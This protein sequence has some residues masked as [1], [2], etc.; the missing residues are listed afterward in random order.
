MFSFLGNLA[1]KKSFKL[2]A[3]IS[4]T[5]AFEIEIMCAN[6]FIIASRFVKHCFLVKNGGG[7]KGMLI[8]RY[9]AEGAGFLQGI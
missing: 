5:E 3:F 7:G 6:V 2:S 8:F 1:K 4:L 9:K